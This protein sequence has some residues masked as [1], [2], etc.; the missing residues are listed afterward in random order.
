MHCSEASRIGNTTVLAMFVAVMVRASARYSREVTATRRAG[1]RAFGAN[2]VSDGG[3][4][5][6]RSSAAAWA[7]RGYTVTESW[8]YCLPKTDELLSKVAGARMYSGFDAK[9]AFHQLPIAEE[10]RHKT[11]FWGSDRQYEWCRMAMG[12][13][14]RSQA[15]Q[16]VMDEALG[17]LLF[18][19]V[20]ADDICVF[21]SAAEMS[22][23]EVF[24]QHLKHSETAFR[25]LAKAGIRL[26]PGKGCMAVRP[27][28]FLGH[29]VDG[30]G[31]FLQH[32]KV[33]AVVEVPP[34]TDVA[35]LRR[36]LGMMSY[37]GKFIEQVAVKRKPLTELTGK[38]QW[39]WGSEQQRAFEQLKAYLDDDEGHEYVVEFASRTCHTMPAMRLRGKLARW[40]MRLS[41]YDFVVRYRKGVNHV[42]ADCLSRGPVEGDPTELDGRGEVPPEGTV[43]HA[44]AFCC[45]TAQSNRQPELSAWARRRVLDTAHEGGADGDLVPS[46]GD[47]HRTRALLVVLGCHHSM[48]Y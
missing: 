12:F 14:N 34:P 5:A 46:I 25:R 44:A 33:E 32:S 10:D 35:G 17:D 22:D 9:S 4:T 20:S 11:A 21:S 40:A 19:A 24:K 18:V 6:E 27:I 31:V 43:R 36:F 7:N 45:A 26:A 29:W 8:A 16:R 28:A 41:E 1:R 47:Q 37:Y 15:W 3:G 48:R 2:A 30:E 42:N 38:V 13:N 39:E 23:G